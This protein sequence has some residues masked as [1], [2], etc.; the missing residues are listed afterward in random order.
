VFSLR[1]KP[2]QTYLARKVAAHFSREL[3]TTVSIN[4]LNVRLFRS[5]ALNGFLVKDLDGDTLLYTPE[6]SVTLRYFSYYHKRI[7]VQLAQLDNGEFYLKKYRKGG[8]NLDFIINYFKSEEEKPVRKEPSKPYTLSLAK[9]ALNNLRFRYRNFASADS[10]KKNAIDFNDLDLY[11]LSASILD[12]DLKD[13]LAQAKIRQLTF[14]EKSGFFLK[15]LSAAATIDSTYLEFDDLVLE[16]PNTRLTNYLRMDFS[17]Y[18]DFSDFVEKVRIRSKLRNSVIDPRDLNYFVPGTSSVDL[19]VAVNGDISGYVGHI[20][21]RDFSVKAGQAT[22]MK[23]N[24]SIT[25]LPNIDETLLDLQFDQ[26]YSNKKDAELILSSITGKKEQLPGMIGKLGDIYF[27]GRFTGFPKDFIADGEFKT[28]LGRI[29]SDVNMKIAKV[30]VYTGTLRAYDFDLGRLLDN[31]DLARTTFSVNVKGQSFDYGS[32][33]EKMAGKISYISYKDYKYTNIDVDGAFNKKLFKGKLQVDDPNVRL[34]FDGGIDLKPALPVFD[35]R[36][37]VRN[38]NLHTLHFTKDTLQVDADLNSNF[39]GNK[40]SNIQGNLFID[41]IRLT[42][43]AHS[44]TVDSVSLVA[45]GTGKTRSMSIKSDILDAEIK[46]EYDLGTLPSYFIATAKQYVPSLSVSYK[47]PEKQDFELSLKLKYFE[48]IGLLFTPGLKIPDGANLNGKFVSSENLFA[49]SG[50]ASKVEYKGVR[51]T[52]LIVDETSMSNSL[53]VIVTSDRINFNDSLYV[54]N[55]NIANILRNDSLSLNVKLSD[56]DAVNQL[57]MNGLIEFGSDT[58]ALFTLLPSDVIIN[59]ESWK[60]P[61]KVR[62]GFD[63]GKTTVTG[64]QLLK[65][66]QV[67][68][69][70]GVVSNDPNDQLVAEF[71]RFKLATFNPLAVGLGMKFDGTLNGKATMVSLLKNPAVDAGLRID[72]MMLNNTSVGDVQFNAAFDNDTRLVNTSM[73]ITKEGKETLRINGDFNAR[74]EDNSLDMDIN[75]NNSELIIFE[76]FVKGLISNLK[77]TVSSNLKLS[78]TLL[79]PVINGSFS[80][81]NAGMTVDYLKTPYRINDRVTVANSV[82]SFNGLVI[83]DPGNNEAK[84]SGTV[85]LRNPSDPYIDVVVT[86]PGSP[87][88][89][90]NTTSKDNPLYYGTAY[91]TG[92]FI[93]RGPVTNMYIDIDARTAAGTV[94]NIPLNAAATV[95]KNEFITFVA[96]DSTQAKPARVN[97]FNGLTMSLALNVDDASEVNIFTDIGK[98][99]GRGQSDNLN[100][101]ISS[102]GDFIMTGTYEITSGRFTFSPR[103]YVNKVF[104]ISSGGSIKWSGDPRQAI[105]NLQATYGSKASLS[106]LY[107]AAGRTPVD[108]S[109]PVEA[110]INLSGNLLKP[111]ITFDLNFPSNAAVKEDLQIYFNDENN[112]YVQALSFLARRSFTAGGG[113]DFSTNEL[114]ST[115]LSAASELLFN[116]LNNFLAQNLGANFLDLNI[117][118]FNEASAT[119]KLFNERFILTGGVRDN[120]SIGDISFI[121]ING[122]NNVDRDVE[123]QYLIRKDGS[124]AF[125]ASNTRNTRNVLNVSNDYVNALGLVYRQDFDNFEELLQIISGKKRREEKKKREEQQQAQPAALP[126][127]DSSTGRPADNFLPEE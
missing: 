44:I 80:L 28:S 72:S 25:G 26:V 36:A 122:K 109:V 113:S 16:T 119:L 111:K 13:H 9:I 2:V 52:N 71:S 78:G 34:D 14:S 110:V 46:G 83:R 73:R 81:N 76:P 98:L 107:S 102:A 29:V 106:P 33:N 115:G 6:L 117:R 126:P 51:I 4:S 19:R 1:F 24:F 79:K 118:S 7:D 69:L 50:G 103:D 65:D 66:D 27:K 64:F 86:M 55:I 82:S 124:L 90:L 41:K 87:F 108:Q 5:I 96:K 32:L 31:K 123:A 63:K 94:F 121:D 15:E 37:T 58:T 30:P 53:N 17:S 93:F 75:M 23:G 120:R 35:F 77:G 11:R 38:A 114:K 85:D 62:I 97:Q 22:Y 45:S 49:L 61:E 70:D 47:K 48:P 59:R 88:L 57:D 84:A 8:T 10:V 54:K 40:L 116:Q 112:V 60:V 20:K 100:L 125:K 89:V 56:K 68:S 42:N 74:S 12:L 99:S 91:G 67:L 104:D 39:V 43:P 95:S 21:A 92:R 105:I 101:T 18:A 127:G 3:N